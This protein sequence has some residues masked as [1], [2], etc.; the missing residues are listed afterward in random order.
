MACHDWISMTFGWPP[1]TGLAESRTPVASSLLG[2]SF[3]TALRMTFETG[4]QLECLP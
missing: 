3:E 4:F 1:G 2:R